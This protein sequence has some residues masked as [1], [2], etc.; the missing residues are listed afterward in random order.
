MS[1]NVPEK[2]A[3]GTQDYLVSFQLLVLF[4][5]QGNVTEQVIFRELLEG[6]SETASEL[7]PGQVIGRY[8]HPKTCTYVV[9]QVQVRC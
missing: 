9:E 3:A 6:G 8:F 7:W 4:T 1:Q 5:D 2:R